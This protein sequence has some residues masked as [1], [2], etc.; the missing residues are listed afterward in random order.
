[1]TCINLSLYNKVIFSNFYYVSQQFRLLTLCPFF[2]NLFDYSSMEILC[3]RQNPT[4]VKNGR[5]AYKSFVTHVKFNVA[6][7]FISLTCSVGFYYYFFSIACRLSI[8]LKFSSKV[9]NSR[10]KSRYLNVIKMPPTRIFL[11]YAY[12]CLCIVIILISKLLHD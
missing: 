5:V 12:I 8:S 1:M 10:K 7:F 11:K 6:P 2:D 3:S 9:V 4:E